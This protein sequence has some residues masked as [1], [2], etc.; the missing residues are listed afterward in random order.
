MRTGLLIFIVAGVFAL[1]PAAAQAAGKGQNREGPSEC[2]VLKGATSGLYGL[3]VSYCATRDQS[4][5]DLNN[6]ASVR[7]AAPSIALLRKYN[8]KRQD[9]DPIMPCFKN[10]GST[11]D[12][13][14]D[15]T[16][17]G[18]DD[19]SGGEP[20]PA[21]AQCPCWTGA[22]LASIDGE[23]P[24]SSLGSPAI[25]CTFNEEN[26]AIHK[27]Q[28]AE[29]YDAGWI[30]T[31]EGVAWASI[32]SGGADPYNG[33]FFSTSSG[34]T[35]DSQNFPIERADAENCVQEIANHCSVM[36]YP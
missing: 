14:D 30:T 2:D 22:D 24:A 31:V 25:A 5:V 10:G 6:V 8:S 20:P 7:A 28:V 35:S 34:T 36:G 16:S 26:G 17:G 1:S 3:C 12:D 13:S 19:T 9:G 18:G 29:G 33:C 32:D 15:D 23:L 21:P 11:D 27:R 4:R